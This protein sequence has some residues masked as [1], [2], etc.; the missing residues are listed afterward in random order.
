MHGTHWIVEG[1]IDPRWPINTRGNIGEVFPEVL[2][3]MSYELGVLAAEAGWRDAYRE[4]GILRKGD[5]TN[6][7][8]VIIGLYG[9]YG[10][11][12]VSYLRMIGVRAPGSSPEA[13]DLTLFG[14]GNPP[15]YMPRKGDKSLLSTL[16]ILGTVLK[17]LAVQEPPPVI[18]DS[19]RL[20]EQ[21]EARQPPLD[22][23]D[24]RLVAYLDEFPALFRQTFRNHLMASSLAAIVSGVLADNAKAAGDPGL[25]TRLLGASGGVLSASYSQ[26]LYEVAK[27]VRADPALMATFDAGI[28]GLADRLSVMPQAREFNR[29]FAAFITR[30]GHRGPNDWEM[31]SRTWENTPDLALVAVDRMRLADYDLSPQARLGDVEQQRQ[32]AFERVWPHVKLMDRGNFKKAIKA[33]PHWARAREATRD[34]AIR[35]MLPPKRVL[36]ELVRRAAQRGGVDDVRQ[37]A[38]LRYREEFPRYLRDPSSLMATIRERWALR[39]RF[40]A[41]T[42]PFFIS[43]QDDVPSIESLESAQAVAAQPAPTGTVLTGDPGSAGVA[44][45]RAR[46]VLDPADAR[47]LQP[48]EILIAPLTDPAWTPL[49]LP[50]AGVVVN[51]GALMSHAVIVSRELGIPCVVSVTGATER[52]P[53]GAMIEIDGATGRVTVLHA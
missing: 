13:I 6:D 48:G 36:R 21:W 10:Y 3:P 18:A 38:M 40:A 31:S 9:G 28:A 17:A 42:P 51:V 52:I 44:R 24:A 32:Q 25:A 49:F 34:R 12:N 20:A 7:D 22:A 19:Y 46:V 1:R 35:S 41:V 47:G 11:L 23:D 50:A 26:E 33:A 43:S 29:E 37:V 4:L 5:F 2:T 53:N 45:G 16:R 14:E 39:E 30:H 8:P 15:P 27:R